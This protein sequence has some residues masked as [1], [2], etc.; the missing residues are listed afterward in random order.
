[1]PFYTNNKSPWSYYGLLA[2]VLLLI[3]VPMLAV[4]A[5]QSTDWSTDV[6]KEA[7]IHGRTVVKFEHDC[8]K[9]WGYTQPRRDYFHVVLP[10]KPCEAPPLM[11]LL[12]SAGGSG[13]SEL[14]GN[15]IRTADA[16]PEFVGLVLNS[17]PNNGQDWWWGAKLL[18]KDRGYHA[19]L[20]P[21]ENRVLATVEHVVQKHKIDR[22]RIYL[23]GVSMGGSGTLG[24]GVCHGDIFAAVRAHVPAGS[25]HIMHRMRFP[26]P[27]AENASPQEQENYLRQVSV[28]DLPDAP[29]I[30]NFSSQLDG[31]SKGQDELLRALHDGRHSV[32][33]TWGPW[34]HKNV[35]ERYNRA[36]YEFP[37]LSIRKNQAYPVFTDATSDDHYPGHGSKQPDQ[38]GQINA[39][40]RWKNIEDTPQR[41]AIELRLV[42][43]D[44]LK[45]LLSIPEQSVADVTLRRLQKFKVE[46]GG[47]YRWELLHGGKRVSS[48]T[49]RPDAAGLL[50]VP[51]VK[52]SAEPAWLELRAPQIHP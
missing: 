21:A 42:R 49:I 28:Q 22:N 13:D 34:G 3:A 6:L 16:G 10:K 44:E 32:V 35:Y 40:F 12:H 30:I 18:E 52:I 15:V 1:M 37:W 2:G 8:L 17:A 7:K 51:R 29:P 41:F 46:R 5:D 19:K 50:T 36:A 14:K 27:P 39:Y 43:A 26:P 24:L 23:T 11:V 45:K 4:A 38:Q 33:F 20:T 31:W 9:P 47:K 48:G 25:G